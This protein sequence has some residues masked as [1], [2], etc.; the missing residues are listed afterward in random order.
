MTTAQSTLLAL[1]WIISVIAW[2]VWETLRAIRDESRLWRELARRRLEVDAQRP[3]T[4][5]ENPDGRTESALHVPPGFRYPVSDED[6][7]NEEDEE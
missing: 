1:V 4:L 7:E 5:D 2:I 3:I 6:E